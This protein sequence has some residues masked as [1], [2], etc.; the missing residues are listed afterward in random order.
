M[1]PGLSRQEQ[2]YI[3]VLPLDV[4]IRVRVVLVDVLLPNKYLMK[5]FSVSKMIPL[6][7]GL[8]NNSSCRCLLNKVIGC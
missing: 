5:S 2:Q 1:R 7:I 4:E 6:P 8:L 3:T